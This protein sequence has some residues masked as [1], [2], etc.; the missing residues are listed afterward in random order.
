MSETSP[1][2]PRRAPRKGAGPGRVQRSRTASPGRVSNARAADVS[3]NAPER[4]ERPDVA[5]GKFRVTNRAIALVAVFV[6][7]ALT[8]GNSLRVYLTQQQAI[9]VAQ[10]E[11]AQRSQSI[12]QL[13]DELKRWQDPAY[14]KAQARTRLGWAM[15]GEVGYKVLGPDGKPLGGGLVEIDSQS[16]T[17]AGEHPS[18]W[19]ERVW[20]SVQAADHPAPAKPDPNQPR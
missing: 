18:T 15:P 12:S 6:V 2:H 14:V 9:A 10:A 11:I 1:R 8:Y 13:Q 5:K 4:T 19:Y 20:G 3:D 17:P 16:T 7:L